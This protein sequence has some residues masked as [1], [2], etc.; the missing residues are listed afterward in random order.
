MLVGLAYL[1]GL[2]VWRGHSLLACSMFLQHPWKV[3]APCGL[4]LASALH[5][6]A[7]PCLAKPF[8]VKGLSPLCRRVPRLYQPSSK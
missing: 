2:R 6:H 3:V 8:P 5:A 4:A 7:S 1:E